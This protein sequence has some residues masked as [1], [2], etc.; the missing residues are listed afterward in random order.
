LATVDFPERASSVVISINNQSSKPC[1]EVHRRV[2][3]AEAA[4]QPGI[5]KVGRWPT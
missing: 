4:R 3:A 5:A 1:I 2:H